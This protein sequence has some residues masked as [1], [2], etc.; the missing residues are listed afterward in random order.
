MDRMARIG[1]ESWIGIS[2][3]GPGGRE[4]VIRVELVFACMRARHYYLLIVNSD[5]YSSLKTTPPE[6]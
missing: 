3:H 6:L 1:P 2:H 4:V 5:N